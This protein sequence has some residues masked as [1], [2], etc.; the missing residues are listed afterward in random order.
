MT[1]LLLAARTGE[2]S[3]LLRLIVATRSDPRDR[4]FVGAQNQNG[5]LRVGP[6]DES[7][8]AFVRRC[9]GATLAAS[10]RCEGDP[11]AVEALAG[12]I[13]HERGFLPGGYSFF[14]DVR[15]KGAE[16]FRAPDAAEAQRAPGPDD[17]AAEL[18]LT[19]L[20]TIRRPGRQAGGEVLPVPRRARRVLPGHPVGGP[21]FP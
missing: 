3:A 10:R 6:A 11:Q 9:A 17:W 20:R 2:D 12:D 21:R 13:A 4:E 15:F 8:E 19:D 1:A 5:L 18:G 14:N 7:A 16:R